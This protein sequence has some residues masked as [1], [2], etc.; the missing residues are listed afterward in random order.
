MLIF[1]V[2]SEA[3]ANYNTFLGF[4]KRNLLTHFYQSICI[5]LHWKFEF[6][7]WSAWFTT[8]NVL[9]SLRPWKD[10]QTRS[11]LSWKSS[12]CCVINIFLHQPVINKSLIRNVWLL[13]KY[14]Q[15]TTII[16]L[17]K[18]IYS[19]S[20]LLTSCRSCRLEVNYRNKKITL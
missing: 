1:L 13:F 8:R 12:F 10:S 18:E 6:Y 14:I 16:A 2:D 11:R 5:L 3:L 20:W 4:K 9:R 19:S 7:F 17:V 15:N